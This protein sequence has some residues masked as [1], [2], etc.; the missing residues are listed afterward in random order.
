MIL[1]DSG[2][3]LSLLE[4]LG[5]AECVSG[6]DLLYT[7]YKD[8]GSSF[9]I[10]IK[11]HAAA[12]KRNFLGERLRI[13]EKRGC[14][15]CIRADQLSTWCKNLG[16]GFKISTGTHK[17][18]CRQTEITR[19]KAPDQWNFDAERHEIDTRLQD[20]V[21]EEL[22]KA[23]RLVMGNTRIKNKGWVNALSSLLLKKRTISRN[24][25]RWER[26]NKRRK[27]EIR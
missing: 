21:I 11:P 2:R 18:S 23:W 12:N 6:T 8:L 13:N 3:F 27:C 9:K 16:S 15:M 19:R 17:C 26:R 14:R 1:W 7:W 22:E 10:S 24:L 5:D 20:E 4:R 25:S